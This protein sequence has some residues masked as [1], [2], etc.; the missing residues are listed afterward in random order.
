IQLIDLREMALRGARGGEGF[1][2]PHGGAV[3]D[4]ELLRSRVRA[5]ELR[6]ALSCALELLAI[7]FPEVS[8]VT[9]ALAPELPARTRSTL[10]KLVVGPAIDPR[11]KS[12]WRGAQAIRRAVLRRG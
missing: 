2:D 4:I 5:G 12:S 9:K 7:F 11:R 10:S 1:W 6:R 3:L 8:P